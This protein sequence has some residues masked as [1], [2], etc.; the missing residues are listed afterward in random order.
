M[1]AAVHKTTWAST[2]RPENIKTPNRAEKT[3]DGIGN[4]S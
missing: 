4:T 3:F 2:E 1:E